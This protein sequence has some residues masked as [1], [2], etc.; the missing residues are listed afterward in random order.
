ML[1]LSSLELTPTYMFTA[2]HVFACCLVS[3][4]VK[5]DWTLLTSEQNKRHY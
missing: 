2:L 1:V 3:L 5:H 4:R